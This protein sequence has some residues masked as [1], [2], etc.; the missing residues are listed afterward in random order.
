VCVTDL[1]RRKQHS[2]RG[3]IS[4][5]CRLVSPADVPG[6]ESHLWDSQTANRL[7]SHRAYAKSSLPCPL[8]SLVLVECGDLLAAFQGL[9]VLWQQIPV[10][11]RQVLL[12]CLL[13]VLE[14]DLG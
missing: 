11:Q 1:D 12:K 10:P 3:L 8:T 6:P 9:V 14:T 5:R 2:Q 7:E 13:D 4:A